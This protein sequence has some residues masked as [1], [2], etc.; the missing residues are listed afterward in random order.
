[1]NISKNISSVTS[2]K[3]V[4]VS[5]K[6]QITIKKSNIVSQYVNKENQRASMKGSNLCNS[7]LNFT[8]YSKDNLENQE[9]IS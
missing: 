3:K 8:Q 2:N 4:S 6:P 7:M 1:M 5:N 9:P